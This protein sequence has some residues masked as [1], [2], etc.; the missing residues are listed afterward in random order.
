MFAAFWHITSNSKSSYVTFEEWCRFWFR[1]PKKYSTTSLPQVLKEFSALET[2]KPLNDSVHEA[3]VIW[4]FQRS[5]VWTPILRLFILVRI[6][7]FVLPLK[8]LGCIRPSELASSFTPGK[9]VEHFPAHYVYAW[10]AWYFRSHHMGVHDFVGAP[11]IAFHG[12]DAIK[13][14]S[15]KEAKSSIY[16]GQDI[17]WVIIAPNDTTSVKYVGDSM[18]SQQVIDFLLSVRS[19]FL[20]LRYDNNCI[21]EP[22]SPHGF[23]RQFGFYQ[24]IPGKLKPPPEKVTRQFLYS[25]FQTSVQLGTYSSFVIPARGL[26]MNLRATDNYTSWWKSIYSSSMNSLNLQ[27]PSESSEGRRSKSQK[28]KA[29]NTP[30]HDKDAKVTRDSYRKG[31]LKIRLTCG[32]STCSPKEPA[33]RG[34]K[35]D[36]SRSPSRSSKDGK[37]SKDKD[38]TVLQDIFDGTDSC[39]ETLS[40]EQQKANF[41][42]AAELNACNNSF[43]TIMKTYLLLPA[44][45]LYYMRAYHHSQKFRV[46]HDAPPIKAA[47]P[48]FKAQD[49]I[50]EAD[51]YAVGFLVKQMKTRL[52]HTPFNNIPVLDPELKELFATSPQ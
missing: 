14:L 36:R 8:D 2:S 51:R 15:Y 52:L 30:P 49:M 20:T 46:V 45:L 22:Y 12:T 50:S 4:I 42:I 29:D 21:A 26:K 11:M 25:Q 1:G 40:D 47:A 32:S 44:T 33:M 18:Q 7:A 34:R 28:R 27:N 13:T 3:F 43:S 23:S 39:G 10:L 17:N 41:D 31:P 6:C 38:R 5:I 48:S 19:C 9:Q 35:V 24:D 37:S 16:S